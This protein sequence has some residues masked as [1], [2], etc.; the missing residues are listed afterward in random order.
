MQVG[1]I[2]YAANSG[3]GILAKSLIDHGIADKILTI[4]H[5]HYRNEDWYGN[6]VGYKYPQDAT[7]FLKS[8]DV[9]LI[10]E[11]AWYWEVVKEARRLG[12]R[13]VLMPMY[14]YTPYPPPI[15]PD[16]CICPSLLDLQYYPRSS[17]FIPVPVEVPWSLRSR[18]HTF[19]HN[20]GH[21][22]RGYRNGT[23]ELLEAMHYVKSPIRL[24]IRGQTE[25]RKIADLFRY[26]E[27]KVDKRVAIVGGTVPQAE[28]YAGVPI[29]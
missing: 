15:E 10:L 9:L 26:W 29:S 16:F 1:I 18:A 4:R 8:I 20:A 27:P 7:E 5:P 6:G 28:L 17:A 22:G 21:G 13:I 2:S 19:I 24:I 11:N 14:E 25:D 12:K 3:L 23:P